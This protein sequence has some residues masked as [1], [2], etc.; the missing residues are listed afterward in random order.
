VRI[1]TTLDVS[2]SLDDV[3]NELRERAEAGLALVGAEQIFGYDALTLLGLV[4]PK[5]PGIE[6]CTAV[7]PV[8]SRHPQVMAQQALTVQ[9]ATGN[10]LVLGIGLSHQI[11][12]ETL[13]GMSYAKPYRYMA[14]YLSALL[15][16]LA[17]EAVA[18]HGEVVTAVTPG[19][20]EIPGATAPPV[21]LA[22]LGPKML[23][24]AGS[25]ADGTATWMC[26]LRTVETHIA[27]TINAAAE[28]AGRPAPRVVVA[29]PVSVTADAAAARARIDESLAIYPNLPSYRAMLD[30]EGA[31]GPSD[32][33]LVGTEE[34]V[35]AQLVQ[36]ENAGA[37]DF[38]AAVVGNREER[39]RTLDLLQSM[40]AG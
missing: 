33:A 28:A 37:T 34:E 23:G 32:V 6:L 18:F 5:V 38:V 11:V 8:Y 22:A 36:L 1:G 10:R 16:M 25:V 21:I 4:G 13:W 19:K 15:P 29:L 27:P 39:A 24:L 2:G 30:L 20:L 9:A 17:G 35:A 3:A 31:T 14:E 40:A 12:V 7:V 26:G